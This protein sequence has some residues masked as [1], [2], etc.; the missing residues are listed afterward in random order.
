[1]YNIM[2]N[3]VDNMFTFTKLTNPWFVESLTGDQ[4][5]YVQIHRL[6]RS[7]TVIALL[8]VENN[9][10]KLN[11]NLFQFLNKTI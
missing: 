5:S 3:A 2:Y 11:I 4:G 6:S 7:T 9:G 8:C 1:M 10:V